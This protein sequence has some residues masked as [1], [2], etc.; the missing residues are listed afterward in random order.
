MRAISSLQNIENIQISDIDFSHFE[1]IKL[2][3]DESHL[4][5]RLVRHIPSGELYFYEFYEEI[6]YLNGNDPQYRTFIPVESEA[7]ADKINKLDIFEIHT[8][9]PRLIAD[10]HADNTRVIKWVK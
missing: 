5:R 9:I 2:Y 4:M 10:W 8:I 6:D 1:N 3:L 7:Q